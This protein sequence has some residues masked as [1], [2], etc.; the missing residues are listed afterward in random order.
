ME[1]LNINGETLCPSKY[2]HIQKLSNP[3]RFVWAESHEESDFTSWAPTEPSG[4]LYEDCVFICLD[5]DI[6]DDRGTE[7]IGWHDYVCDY[8]DWHAPIHAL[9]ETEKK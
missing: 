8:T 2:S 5:P 6:C 3:G 7:K 1:D 4:D 9:C